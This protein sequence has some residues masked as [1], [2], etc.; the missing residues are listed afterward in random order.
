MVRVLSVYHFQHQKTKVVEDIV[1][2]CLIS[3]T[4]LILAKRNGFIEIHDLT[5][6]DE[7]CICSFV[8]IDDIV[9]VKHCMQ[10]NFIACIEEKKNSSK[11]RAS[12]R[13]LR[14]YCKFEQ[15]GRD[16]LGIKARIAGVTTPIYSTAES[17]CLEM[18]EI[19]IKVEPQII[20]CCQVIIKPISSPLDDL[21]CPHSYTPLIH[22]LMSH[23]AHQSILFFFFP[24]A[25]HNIDIRKHI[26]CIWKPDTVLC[27]Q[28]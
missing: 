22:L 12:T 6:D 27:V 24:M 10:G 17:Y 26:H 4:K 11:G 18:I 7:D 5:S 16:S 21:I 20:A 19:P 3:D 25:L 2:S 14:V 13:S 15:P 1:D 28:V 9:C 8:T 23:G